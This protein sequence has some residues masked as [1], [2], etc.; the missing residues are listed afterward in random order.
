VQIL[1][2]AASTAAVIAV[3]FAV[4]SSR[5]LQYWRNTVALFE[6]TAAV[7]ADNPSAQFSIGVGLEKSGQI[8][9]AMAQYRV[10][11]AIDPNYVKAHYNLGQLLRKES[12]WRAAAGHYQAALRCNPNDVPTHLNLAG[13]LQEL[14]QSAEAVSHYEEALR[15]D[16]SST[17]ALNNLAWLLATSPQSSLRNGAR[18]VE[19]AERAC[20][21]SE[22]KQPI[23]I[24]TLAAAFAEAGRFEEAIQAAEKACGVATEMGQPEVVAKNTELREL[25]RGKQPYRDAGTTN[26]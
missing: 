17:E 6:H 21:L 15:L 11:L 22:F 25:Y 18:A 20:T 5:Q 26:P 10:A 3:T 2:F 4:L 14:G 23:M 1:R 9:Q 12:H 16:P 8:Q 24:G 19:L 13:V 7:T